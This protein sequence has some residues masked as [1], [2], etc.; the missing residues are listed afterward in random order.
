MSRQGD[1]QSTLD[2]GLLDPRVA[3]L[4]VAIGTGE[5]I[6]RKRQTKRHSPHPA[7]RMLTG[8]AGPRYSLAV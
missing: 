8:P 2:A 3:A 7:A 5:L 6:C 4:V 1:L